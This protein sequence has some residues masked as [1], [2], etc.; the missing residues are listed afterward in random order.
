MLDLTGNP[1]L[2]LCR[3]DI[4]AV[5]LRMPRLGL[6]LLGKWP[7]CT[8]AMD[9]RTGGPTIQMLLLSSTARPQVAERSMAQ[10]IFRS[11]PSASNGHCCR[12]APPHTLPCR[13]GG[14]AGVAGAAAASAGGGL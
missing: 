2:E 8:A 9:W 7:G 1:Q 6:L 14:G 5:L 11:S 3:A 4:D 13:L 10:L 12:A